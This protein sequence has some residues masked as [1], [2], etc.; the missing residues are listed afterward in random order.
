DRGQRELARDATCS[1]EVGEV[2][3]RELLAPELLDLREQ[4]PP[5]TELAIVR[6][7]LMGV[8][9]VGKVGDLSQGDRQ[10]VGERLCLAEPVCY[11]RLVCR[12]RLE[13]LAREPLARLQRGVALLTQFAPHGGVL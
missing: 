10:L 4:V 7:C 9:A 12:R 3:V 2:V 1:F 11:R 8:L 13:R 5:R 6:R